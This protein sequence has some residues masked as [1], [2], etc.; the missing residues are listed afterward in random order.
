MGFVLRVRFAS[1][2]CGAAAASALGLYI[3]QKD[4][5]TAHHVVSQ[6][7]SSLY[8]SLDGRIS[9]LEKLKGDEAPKEAEAL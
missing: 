2:F 7:M 4:Y 5:K 6:Q 8:G 9:A 3:L 1:F